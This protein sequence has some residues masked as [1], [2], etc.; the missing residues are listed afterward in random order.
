MSQIPNINAASSTDQAFG[1]ANT[2]NDLDLEND[3]LIAQISQI[4]EVGATEQLSETLNA[5]LL[6]QNIA[7]ATNLIGAD[8]EAISDDNQ[9]VTGIV[10]R[11]SVSEGSP[12]LHLDLGPEALPGEEPG[13]LQAGTYQYR[14]VW[15]DAEGNQYA[16]DPLAGTNGGQGAIRLDHSNQSILISG[17]PETN[18]N[19]RVYRT[20]SS[21]TSSFRLVDTITDGKQSTYLDTTSDTDLSQAVLTGTP[22]LL[23]HSQRSFTVSLKNVGEIRPPRR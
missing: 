9:R 7:S 11:V 20:D 13:N 16:I 4:R 8:I 5:V 12:K 14:V 23:D 15:T 6:G 2:L 10:D 18:T 21:G 17:L 19:K 22:T 3:E 1:S